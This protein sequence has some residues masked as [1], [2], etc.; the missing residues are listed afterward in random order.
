MKRAI[1]ENAMSPNLVVMRKNNTKAKR[2][3][4]PKGT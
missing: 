2:I 4:P 1:K 3:V